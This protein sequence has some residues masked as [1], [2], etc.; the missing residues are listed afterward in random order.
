[1]ERTRTT[2]RAIRRIGFLALNDFTMVALSCAIEV[3]RMANQISQKE[4]YAWSV[5][6]PSGRTAYAGDG[7]TQARA[8]SYP[9]AGKLD[10]VLVCGGAKR[11]AHFDDAVLA[12]LRQI[13]RDGVVLGGLSGGTYALAEAGLLDGYK[14][15]IDRDDAELVRQTYPHI[16]I[17]DSPFVIDRNRITCTGGIAPIHLMLS[18]VAS[19]FGYERAVEISDRLAAEKARERDPHDKIATAR[20]FG[21]EHMA[22]IEIV[23]LMETNLE[24]VLPLT[25]LARL[26]GI[27]LRQAQRIFQ[28]SLGTTPTKHYLSLRLKRARE[29][30]FQTPLSI[31]QISVACGFESPGHFSRSY[32]AFYGVTPSGERKQKL[33]GERGAKGSSSTT[34]VEPY[35]VAQNRRYAP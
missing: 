31:T 18:L 6:T 7:L 35:R 26:A 23:S 15:A 32:K 8:V 28:D 29:L 12:L 34:A 13:E 19:G 16:T 17:Q 21:L 33:D 3:L 24:E 1:M 30:I 2:L 27:S 14:C 22:L 9:D 25:E 11:P 10:V 4:D 5:I 20:R